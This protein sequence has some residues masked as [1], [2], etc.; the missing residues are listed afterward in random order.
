MTEILTKPLVS[1]I[2]P[3]YKTEEFVERC[4]E[5]LCDQTFRDFE[6]ICVDDCSPD[7]SAMRAAQFTGCLPSLTIHSH[8]QNLGL[9]EA[10]NTGIRL[11]KG[12]YIASVDSDDWVDAGFLEHLVAP[13]MQASGPPVDLVIAGFRRVNTEGKEF[14]VYQPTNK[15]YGS[16][17]DDLRNDDNQID[18]FNLTNPA[19]WNKLWRRDVFL[20]HDIWFP[21]NYYYQDLATTPRF[22]AN[23]NRVIRINSVDYNYL[24]R[25]GAISKTGSDKHVLDY[26]RVFRMLYLFLNE[27]DLI[28]RHFEGFRRTVNGSFRFHSENIYQNDWEAKDKEVYINL[29]LMAKFGMAECLKFLDE[30][31]LQPQMQALK[32]DFHV[33][34]S[35]VSELEKLGREKQQVEIA[36]AHARR[37][38]WKYLVGAIKSRLNR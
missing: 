16:S 13:V 31:S 14:Q 5:S 10:R 26:L 9:G 27:N 17:E 24:V 4:I 21:G 33:L 6:V 7:R 35:V 20:K 34:D 19:F 23:S 36:L 8:S 28:T 1:V 29:L 12:Q 3:M 18:I 15:P 32:S 38:P 11:A 37:Y 30:K 22:L 25:E 2:V